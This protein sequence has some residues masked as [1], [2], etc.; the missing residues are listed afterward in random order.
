[1]ILAV[2]T[3]I[4]STLVFDLEKTLFYPKW[5]SM[6]IEVIALIIVNSVYLAVVINH[7]TQCE[8]IIFYVN[9][10]R[11]RLEEKSITL[12]EAMQ[13]ILDVRMALGNLNSTVS[14]M[15]TLVSLNFVEK[16]IIGKVQLLIIFII[17]LNFMFNMT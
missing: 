16:F 8:M 17:Y 2:F 5:T 3:Y 4:L 7:A 10:I 13:Q 12:K 1:V 6:L 14:K 9:E 15:A 11:T